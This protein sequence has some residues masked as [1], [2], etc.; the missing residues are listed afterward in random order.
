[1]TGGGTDSFEAISDGHIYL[2][3]ELLRLDS[4]HNILEIGCGIGRDAIPLTKILSDQ[5]KYLGI[6]IIERSINW[7]NENISAKY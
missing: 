5:S 3:R 6:D 4:K 2:L 1:M 7:C